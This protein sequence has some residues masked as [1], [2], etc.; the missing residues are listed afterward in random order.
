MASTSPSLNSDNWIGS[1]RLTQGRVTS[2]TPIITGVILPAGF[3]V[4]VVIVI[5][6]G[7]VG[8]TLAFDGIDP[9]G[10]HSI[11]ARSLSPSSLSCSLLP[12]APSAG[13]W[14]TS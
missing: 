9:Y 12:A 1:S 14:A 2:A 8:I 4:L 7:A 5:F 6:D 3:V 13:L 11:W 10:V